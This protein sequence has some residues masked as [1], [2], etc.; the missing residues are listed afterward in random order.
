M[1]TALA[2]GLV[3]LAAQALVFARVEE[4]RWPATLLV[5][6]VNLGLGL[7]LVALKLALTH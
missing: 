5:L 1:W 7:A 6:T 2:V 3:V 4:L